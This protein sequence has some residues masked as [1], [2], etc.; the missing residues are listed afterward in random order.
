MNLKTFWKRGENRGDKQDQEPASSLMHKRQNLL[1]RE[2]KLCATIPRQAVLSHDI[3]TKRFFE[4][5]AK[6]TELVGILHLSE[7]MLTTRIEKLSHQE[8][9]LAV[10][11]PL[12]ISQKGLN[13]TKKGGPSA[14]FEWDEKSLQVRIPLKKR[15]RHV[16]KK[17]D[18]I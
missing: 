4:W 9:Y 1:W 17:Q 16:T 14:I 18:E 2:S 8:Q 15:T 11:P 13:A 7:T 12:Y 10:V 3:S 5:Q 6:T